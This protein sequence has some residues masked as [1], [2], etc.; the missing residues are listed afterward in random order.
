MFESTIHLITTA[1]PL[2]TILT[3]I[4]GALWAFWLFTVSQRQKNTADAEDAA[5]RAETRKLESQK[6]FLELK[7]KIYVEATQIMGAL[8]GEPVNTPAWMASYRKFW[9]F[10]W[11]ELSMVESEE[12]EQIMIKLG[13]AVKE[14]HDSD[15]ER[16]KLKLRNRS[17][18]LAHQIRTEIEL[19]W[20][21]DTQ[22]GVDSLRKIEEVTPS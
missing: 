2:V 4:V 15:G 3:T 1:T 7:L 12:I 5:R 10:Y 16:A 19:A 11:S 13:D 17:Y 18:E 8:I 20:G 22:T 6:P 14:Y 21:A 9:S